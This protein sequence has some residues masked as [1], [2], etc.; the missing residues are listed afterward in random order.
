MSQPYTKKV[1]RIE[2]DTALVASEATRAVFFGLSQKHA[3]F[4]GPVRVRDRHRF[5]VDVR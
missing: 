4:A 5:H 3:F 2:Y 1:H